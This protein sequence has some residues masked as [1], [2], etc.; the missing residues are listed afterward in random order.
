MDNGMQN[1]LFQPTNGLSTED[2]IAY[3]EG[4]L[5]PDETRA[6]DD[7]LAREPAYIDALRSLEKRLAQ[8]PALKSRL[9]ETDAAVSQSLAQINIKSGPQRLNWYIALAASLAFFVGLTWWL[10]EPS[11]ES[12]A[13]SLLVHYPYGIRGEQ[14]DQDLSAAMGVYNQGKSNPIRY[15]EAAELLRSLHAANPNSDEISL[16]LGMSLALSG[17]TAESISF[18]EPICNSQTSKLEKPILEDACWYL[19]LS[20]IISGKA[21]SSVPLLQNISQSSTREELRLKARRLL[22]RME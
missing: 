2:M 11:A 19:A 10:R 17:K 20:Y 15:G 7:L 21:E 13:G 4:T 3:L 8:N 9:L 18:L 6:V 12:M 22:D 16:Y 14:P 5:S 1:G